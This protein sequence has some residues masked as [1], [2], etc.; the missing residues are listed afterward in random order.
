MGPCFSVSPLPDDINNSQPSVTQQCF[1]N[2]EGRRQGD[3]AGSLSALKMAAKQVQNE[4]HGIVK[5]REEGGDSCVRV[6]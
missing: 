5:V 6:R 2:L 4:L 3:I 1:S